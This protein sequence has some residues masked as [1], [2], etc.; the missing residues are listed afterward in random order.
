MCWERHVRDVGCEESWSH[1]FS[2]QLVRAFQH[3]QLANQLCEK[4]AAH[5]PPKQT[6][7]RRVDM[8]KQGQ[9][10][11]LRLWSEESART[12]GSRSPPSIPA[13]FQP[14]SFPLFLVGAE[15]EQPAGPLHQPYS[16]TAA[17]LRL[18]LGV[19]FRMLLHSRNNRAPYTRPKS[20][21][22]TL[23]CYTGEDTARHEQTHPPP[24]AN[25][26][27]ASACCATTPSLDL[28]DDLIHVL[29]MQD[30]VLAHAL[31][32]VLHGRAPHPRHT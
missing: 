11:T 18:A 12:R 27:D 1:C 28:L 5:S 4:L 2:L 31:R 26:A 15:A 22:T 13:C 10:N 24:L 3:S 7:G 21:R 29:I 23:F 30:V 19:L 8:G 6:P 25:P 9:E 20:N 14:L 32:L 16:R 17:P